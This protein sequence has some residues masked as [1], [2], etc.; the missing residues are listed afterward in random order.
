MSTPNI[1]RIL[2]LPQVEAATGY[3]RSHIYNLEARGQFPKRLALGARSVGWKESAIAA[4]LNSRQP[5]AA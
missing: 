2:R 3:K 4:W 1:D 5:K